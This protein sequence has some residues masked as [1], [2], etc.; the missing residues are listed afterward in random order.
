VRKGW[1]L[2]LAAWM[3]AG[4]AARGQEQRPSDSWKMEGGPHPPAQVGDKSNTAIE[5]FRVWDSLPQAQR[6]ELAT[7]AGS[8]S[9]EKG[10]KLDKN[11]RH[12][13]EEYRSHIEALMQC[14][15]S[16]ECDW[17]VDVE[18]GWM[19]LLPHLGYLRGSARVIRMD[20]YRCIDDG[21]Y[22]SAAER[23][24]AII[25]M[26]NQTRTDK[27][28]ISA[29]VGAAICSVGLNLTDS[30]VNEHQLSPASARLVLNALKALPRNDIFGSE[31]AIRREQYFSVDWARQRYKG[32]HAG[33]LMM[34]EVAG[35]GMS[36]DFFSQFIYGMNEQ[37]L[38]ADLDRFSKY[39]DAAANAWKQP[40][41]TVLLQELSA[42]VWE[43]QFGLVA[44]VMAPSIERVSMSINRAKKDIDRVTRELEVIVHANDAN[45]P[46]V[47]GAPAGK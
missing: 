4:V 3:A 2:V 11:S 8:A 36:N 47:S 42:E 46:V 14:A 32:E 29:L 7:A 35:Q 44:R 28:M 37:R 33:A 20:A 23:I 12:L 31:S 16:G 22:A 41:N 15:G 25:Q 45:A 27:I 18:A 9:R 19:G 17:G 39:F 40:D 21:S 1:L 30:M 38:D 26:S 34:Y 5:Y 24:A 10:E 6:T 13:C 43:G